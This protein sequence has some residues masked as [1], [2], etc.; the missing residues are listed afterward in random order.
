MQVPYGQQWPYQQQQPMVVYPNQQMMPM[1]GYQQQ[2]MPMLPSQAGQQWNMQAGN[3]Q[4]INPNVA[5]ARQ[6]AGSYVPNLPLRSMVS[7]YRNQIAESLIRT[8]SANANGGAL[9]S[10]LYAQM[11]SGNFCNQLFNEAFVY[12]G[13]Y[14]EILMQANATPGQAL[15]QAVANIHSYFKARM[16]QNPALHGKLDQATTAN[17][18]NAVNMFAQ[19]TLP[20]IHNKLNSPD[21]AIMGNGV[22]PNQMQQVG[23]VDNRFGMIQTQMNPQPG[24]QQFAMPT[25]VNYVPPVTSGF[26]APTTVNGNGQ[27]AIMKSKP[28][29]G[30]GTAPEQP[31]AQAPTQHPV[32]SMQ[33]SIPQVAYPAP[34]PVNKIVAEVGSTT[35]SK[36]LANPMDVQPNTQQTSRVMIAQNTMAESGVV[37]GTNLAP[38]ANIEYTIEG[39]EASQ[40]SSS[41]VEHDDKMEGD[42]WYYGCGRPY[43][44]YMHN[45]ETFYDVSV[46]ECGFRS[47]VGLIVEYAKHRTAPFLKSIMKV[48][49]IK[50]EQLMRTMVEGL[51][52][53]EA[54][55]ITTRINQENQN[56]V[57]DDESALLVENINLGVIKGDENLSLH[58]LAIAELKKLELN[59]DIEN[60]I[61]K[62]TKVSFGSNL[63]PAVS[64]HAR[65]IN[66][67]ASWQSLA[68]VVRDLGKVLPPHEYGQ[69]YQYASEAYQF[70]LRVGLDQDIYL[71]SGFIDEYLE[72]GKYLNSLENF[73]RSTYTESALNEMKRYICLENCNLYRAITNTDENFYGIANVEDV[74]LL[75]LTDE[76]I[77]LACP[78][79]VGYVNEVATPEL[80]AFCLRALNTARSDTK[81]IRLVTING[82]VMTL[83]REI[84]TSEILMVSL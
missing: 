41:I 59:L 43:I 31:M 56:L 62:Y 42:H 47:T 1:V 76:Q 71:D 12:A 72:V 48:T 4:Y 65:A 52:L 84:G 3:M 13:A 61:I 7:P 21:A 60:S 26:Q 46:G 83:M 23:A 73:I 69:F 75:P 30:N 74:Y 66:T 18:M 34:L 35:L 78:E 55:D 6:N 45:Q 15:E 70:I 81:K 9:D 11:S 40:K 57:I 79:H 33:T 38:I 51:A 29:I 54:A 27:V 53:K 20:L 39:L 14:M 77:T 8:I 68:N 16:V 17:A 49:D 24:V 36:V 10:G 2:M 82:T 28:L 5:A 19:T 50:P 44:V 63:G 67:A 80:H 22:I 58:E 64:T 32:S 37:T 25:N